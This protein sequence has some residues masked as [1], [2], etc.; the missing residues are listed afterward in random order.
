MW[1]FINGKL[2]VDIGGRHAQLE[3]SIT[4]D[5]AAAERLSLTVGGLYEVDVFQAEVHTSGSNYQLTLGGFEKVVTTCTPRCGD[6][7]KTKFEA[8]DDGEPD[9]GAGG[10]N[11][12]AP[13]CVLGPRCG[14]GVVDA[15]Y[16]EECDDGN[17]VNGDGC[18]STC[19][20]VG[21]PA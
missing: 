14:D 2:A 9:G 8:C 13:G 20:R 5:A 18:S 15:E 17:L 10:Y 21:G 11:Q 1:V 12:C 4:L 3:G 6:G 7:I 16:G 19:K